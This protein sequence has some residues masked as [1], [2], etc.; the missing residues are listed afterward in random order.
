MARLL[1]ICEIE[2]VS[3]RDQSRSAA[4]MIGGTVF[5]TM[6]SLVLTKTIGR[7]A[8]AEA[9][10]YAAFPMALMTSSECTWLK[11][12]STVSRSVLVLIGSVAILLMTWAAV[13]IGNRI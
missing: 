11:R 6:L 9:L 10:G 12:Y 3:R 8:F 4:W 13:A 5:L 7:S 2:G 1:N